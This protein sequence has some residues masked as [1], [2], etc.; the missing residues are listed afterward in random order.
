MKAKI[1]NR[2]IIKPILQYIL[3]TAGVSSY[4]FWCGQA[5][6]ECGMC[7]G[8]GSFNGATC[9]PCRGFGRLCTVHEADW[10]E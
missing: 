2:E 9:K 3:M 5:L 7:K 8:S 4:C 6:R 10:E 1:A